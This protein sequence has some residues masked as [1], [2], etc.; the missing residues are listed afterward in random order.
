MVGYIVATLVGLLL[1]GLGIY[2]RKGH[3]ELLHSYHRKRVTKEDQPV[4]AR[5]IG[6]GLILVGVGVV[7][8]GAFSIASL[9]LENSLLLKVGMGIMVSCMVIGIGILFYAMIR[10]NKGIF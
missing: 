2:T 3:I 5:L 10:Y 6:L 9:L 4:F 8:G 7:I 1:I